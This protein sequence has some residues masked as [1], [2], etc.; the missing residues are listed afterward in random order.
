[1]HAGGWTD[2]QKNR[3]DRLAVESAE[4]D[5]LLEKA[6]A[7]SRDRKCSKESVCVREEWR[8]PRRSRLNQVPRAPTEVVRATRD[9]RSAV[10][11]GCSR[12]IAERPV[13]RRP[14]KSIK[15]ATSAQR[16]R[17]SSVTVPADDGAAKISAGMS[18]SREEVCSSRSLRCKRY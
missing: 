8:C 14:R 2:E 6:Q 4:I 16:F 11:P 3:K 1:M 17:Q 12:L 5:R 9:R 18:I 13:C 7:K 10:A 15:D